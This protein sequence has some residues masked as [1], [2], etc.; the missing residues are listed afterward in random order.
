MTLTMMIMGAVGFM[1]LFGVANGVTVN[2]G[3]TL[4]GLNGAFFPALQAAYALWRKLCTTIPSTGAS[5]TYKWLGQITAPREW[6]GKRQI[7]S[8]DSFGMT[9]VNKT[10]ED[11]IGI[12]R[13]ELADDQTGQLAI[14]ARD[15]A[16]RFAQHPDGLLID[17]LVNGHTSLCYD[18]QYFYDTDHSE[19]SSGSQSNDLTG[20]IVNK[21]APT[22]AEF[23][24]AFSA[25][26]AAMMTFKDDQGEYLNQAFGSEG[27]TGLLVTVPVTMLAVAKE[28]L[29]GAIIGNNS[30]VLVS[31]AEVVAIPRLDA[32]TFMVHKVDTPVGPI[33]F[34]QREAVKTAMKDDPEDKEVKYMADG[35]YNMGY[36]LWQ[37]SVRYEFTTSGG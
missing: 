33:I 25:C 26:I 19:G 17:L 28:C 21:D 10:W 8:L 6:K 9:I 4:R 18:G 11:G 7:K 32:D 3:V 37:N 12:D 27:L 13:D 29:E 23:K 30:N 14:R 20:A 34:Q 1:M 36:G 31:K 5:E 22:V 2:T 35:R 16:G 15:L 24:A